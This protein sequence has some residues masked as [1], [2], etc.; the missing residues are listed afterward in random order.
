MKI[1]DWTE[2]FP[3][4]VPGWALF[5]IQANEIRDRSLAKGKESTDPKDDYVW[6]D[7][8]YIGLVAYFEGFARYH[9]ASCVN[10]C[11]KLLTHFS[12]VRHSLS[13]PLQDIAEMKMLGKELG[14]LLADKLEFSTPKDINS[15]FRDL[16]SFAPL[17]SKECAKY[18]KILHD[19]NHLVHHAGICTARYLRGRKGIRGIGCEHRPYLDSIVITPRRVVEVADFLLHIA[20]KIVTLSYMHLEGHREIWSSEAEMK[21][22]LKFFCWSPDV[23]GPCADV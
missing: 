7:L 10:A 21:E 1:R 5:G 14:F 22:Y 23:F 17:N 13:L 15:T 6:S 9:F 11:P 4:G 19:R 8:S 3:G 20:E 18:D 16:L 12:E 2:L